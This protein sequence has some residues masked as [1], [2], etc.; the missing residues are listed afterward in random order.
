M[1]DNTIHRAVLLT[2]SV[3][4][5]FEFTVNGEKYLDPQ[6]PEA[7]RDEFIGLLNEKLEEFGGFLI[8]KEEVVDLT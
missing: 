7:A 2:I 6:T 8:V 4:H 1:K 3:Q 5:V